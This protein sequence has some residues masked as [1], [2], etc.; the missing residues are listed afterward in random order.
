MNR[1]EPIYVT[2]TS[3][4]PLEEYIGYLRQIWGSN[5]LTNNGP[6]VQRLEQELRQYLD[7][8][9][10]WYVNNGTTALLIALKAL[11]LQGE[12]ITTPFSYVATTGVILWENL[13]PVFVDVRPGDLTINPDQIEAAITP[14]TS[15]ILATH[16]YGFPCDVAAIEA[17]ARRHSLKVIYDAAHTFGC[18]LN[19]RHLAAY[20]NVSCLSFHATKIF[21]TGEGGAVVVNGDRDLTEQVRLMRSFGHHGND[22]RCMGIN[23]K[24]SELHAAM[25]L[26]NLPRTQ[27][28]IAQRKQQYSYY[29]CLLKETGCVVPQ[30]DWRKL[31]YNYAYFPVMLPDEEC[32]SKSLARLEHLGIFPRRYFYPSLNCLPYI[33]GVHCPVSE[34]AAQTIL[35]LPMSEQVTPA[36]QELVA[37]KLR[38]DA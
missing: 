7:T 21:H 29:E 25:G 22:H 16:V 4:P 13:T 6:L 17:I 15:A 33:K 20:G 3:L 14:R 18:R 12:I 8:P 11:N 2:R 24:N 34:R 27:E 28:S 38:T 9:Q 23:G 37:R 35:C 19:G 26:C 31:E 30:P 5:R 1:Q 10:L 32:V 36:I